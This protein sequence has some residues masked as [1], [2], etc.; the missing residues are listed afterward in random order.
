MS[1]EFSASEPVHQ[2]IESGLVSFATSSTQLFNDAF[3]V[4]IS[5][6]PSSLRLRPRAHRDCENRGGDYTGQHFGVRQPKG[7]SLTPTIAPIVHLRAALFGSVFCKVLRCG[8]SRAI[9]GLL[10]TICSVV[11]GMPSQYALAQDSVPVETTLSAEVL[12]KASPNDARQ[13]RR[14]VPAGVITQGDV[15]FYTVKI[16]N[17]ASEPARD[18]AVIQRIPANTTYVP[19]SATGPSVDITFSVDS[20]NTFKRANELT[21]ITATGE[22]RPA[23]PADYTHIRW[24]L[25]NV[26][27]PGAVALARFQAVFQ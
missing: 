19:N 7:T 10:V 23:T 14:L 1:A 3:D 16:R 21:V 26:L 2:W 20:G 4:L 12:E 8:I 22:T 17:P 11:S 24:Q 15:V 27:A 13:A 6:E 5:T 18:V 9:Y 25:R